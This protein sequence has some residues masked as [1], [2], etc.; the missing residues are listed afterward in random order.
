MVVRH[1]T[2]KR[3]M[4]MTSVVIF[5]SHGCVM[6]HHRQNTQ[7]R[8]ASESLKVSPR[9]SYITHDVMPSHWGRKVHW[10]MYDACSAKIKISKYSFLKGMNLLYLPFLHSILGFLQLTL[11]VTHVWPCIICFNYLG[12]EWTTKCGKHEQFNRIS[13]RIPVRRTLSVKFLWFTT[14]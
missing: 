14:M 10:C 8:L 5:S 6:G 1:N 2:H 4:T 13:C 3:S 9:N 11:P 12:K 7:T